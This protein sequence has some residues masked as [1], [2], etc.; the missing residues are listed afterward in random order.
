MVKPHG[1]SNAKAFKDLG[2]S[3]SGSGILREREVS[4][5]NHIFD[6]NQAVVQ[7]Q[8]SSAFVP[9]A[10]RLVI[11]KGQNYIPSYTLAR[12]TSV[13]SGY[14]VASD[15]L[16][17][18]DARVAVSGVA[19]EKFGGSVLV[20]GVAVS[21]T[22]SYSPADALGAAVVGI[23]GIAL[24]IRGQTI[25]VGVKSLHGNITTIGSEDLVHAPAATLR[26]IKLGSDQL[27]VSGS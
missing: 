7:M 3:F 27:S 23:H 12:G 26:V 16:Y 19:I 10:G 24:A 1:I 17:Q 25:N 9:G 20:N 14:T 8:K 6:V 2:N 22:A 11:L 21:G 13:G 5:G 18:V 4:P 15:G